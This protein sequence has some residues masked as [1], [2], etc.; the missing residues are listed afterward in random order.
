[1]NVPRHG[2]R[3]L[4][5]TLGLLVLF[6]L[7]AGAAPLKGAPA[8]SWKKLSPAGSPT[9][10]AAHA[11]AYDPVGHDVVMFGGFDATS[12]LADTWTF[13]GTSW[14]QATPATSPTARAGAAMADDSVTGQLVLFGGYD[15]SSYLGD[16]WLWD[17]ATSTWRSRSPI[18]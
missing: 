1:M 9:A 10:R 18:H 2:S 3:C 4:M 14:N 15:G 13:D 11:M 17:G 8:A 16:T 6:A 5:I 12:Y 7:P